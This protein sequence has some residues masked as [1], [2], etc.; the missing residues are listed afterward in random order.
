VTLRL[1]VPTPA[2][3]RRHWAASLAGRPIEDLQRITDAYRL[4]GGTIRRVATMA[5]STARLDGRIEIRAGDVQDA[6]RSLRSRALETLAPHVPTSGS[7]DDLVTDDETQTELVLLEERCRGRER[8]IEVLSP[9]VG[10]HSAG[11]RVLFTGPS[12]TGKTLAARL[13]A[14]VLGM[15]LHALQLATVVDKYLG[16]TEKNLTAVFA[17]A[18]EL[19]TI[20]LL[21]EGDALLTRRTEVATSNDRY[22]NL[23]TNHLLQ[24]LEAHDGIV[25]ITTN[26]GDRIDS[27][28]Q[29]RIDV[30]VEFRPPDAGLRWRLWRNH[31]PANHEVDDDAL[32]EIAS[33]C[34]LTGGQI[35]NA[36]LHAWLLAMDVS[37][38]AVP[39]TRD[40]EA[41]VRREY[42]KMGTVCPLRLD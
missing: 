6:S 2:E 25:V 15:D 4:S 31:L 26:A 13:L 12:G 34:Q 20:L 22:A 19:D 14:S 38:D 17:R 11:V 30:V 9:A 18:A 8:L 16:E 42:R 33:R 27:A 36:V 23:Q 35:R 37:D 7:W 5:A 39:S 40:V 41:A 32:A 10:L 1:T 29:R 3:R 24:Q 28:F 21:D